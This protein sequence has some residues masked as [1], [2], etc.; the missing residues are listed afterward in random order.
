MIYI[1]KSRFGTGTAPDAKTAAAMRAAIGGHI[2]SEPDSEPVFRCPGCGSVN[3]GFE[4]YV[5]TLGAV[6]H[7]QCRYCGVGF[8]E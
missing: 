7:Y 5:G 8:T 6:R 3:T 1:V 2:E 4:S